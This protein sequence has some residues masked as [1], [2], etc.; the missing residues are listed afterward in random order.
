MNAKRLIKE[1]SPDQIDTD[2]IQDALSLLAAN[3]ENSLLDHGAE[4]GKDYTYMDLY[5][6]AMKYMLADYPPQNSGITF[7]TIYSLKANG[8]K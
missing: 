5:N 2:H 4:P 3:I 7:G 6:L 1:Y 8:S